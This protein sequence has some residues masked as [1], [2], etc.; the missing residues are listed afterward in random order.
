MNQ[1][2]TA[3]SVYCSSL[4]EVYS[5]EGV[6]YFTPLADGQRS[7]CFLE[8]YHESNTDEGH[9]FGQWLVRAIVRLKENR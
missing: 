2:G 7:F 9:F 5:V 4:T 8:G 3:D 1:S 6:F